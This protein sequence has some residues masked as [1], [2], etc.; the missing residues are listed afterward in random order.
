MLLEA[1]AGDAVK[2]TQCAK[3][4][5]ETC[6][7]PVHVVPA[8]L[9]VIDAGVA[10][11]LKVTAICEFSAT[12]VAASAGAVLATVIAA[13]VVNPVAVWNCD[14][15]ATPSLSFAAVVT[16]IRYVVEPDKGAAGVNVYVALPLEAAG[17][18]LVNATQVLKLLDET[19]IDPVQVV[20]VPVVIDDTV[21]ARLKVTAIVE[22]S[23]IAVAASAGVVPDT[24]SATLVV[25]PVA[26]VYCE[27]I[28]TPS[29]SRAAVV[30][31][32]K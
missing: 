32:I 4:S 26:L 11:R 25:K 5:A 23:A 8:V 3:L 14:A 15:K 7:A 9:A 2:A 31:R 6:N 1:V 30:T 21:A 18:A 10:A 24:A 27:E 29:L 19:C 22:F 13:L 17:V 20:D 12:A 28:G 16:R